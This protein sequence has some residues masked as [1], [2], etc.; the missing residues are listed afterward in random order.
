MLTWPDVADHFVADGSWRDI[1]VL[2]TTSDDWTT[3]LRWLRRGNYPIKFSVD[4]NPEPCPDTADDVLW[5]QRTQASFMLT[6]DVPG[7]PKCH[8]FTDEEIEFDLDPKE[9]QDDAALQ[10]LLA[11]TRDLGRTVSKPV[12]ITPENRPESPLIRYDPIRD[13]FEQGGSTMDDA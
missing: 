2:D 10:R 6:V 13:E 4:N 12:I 8:F 3:M 1:Y 7:R 5:N 9:I 11:L